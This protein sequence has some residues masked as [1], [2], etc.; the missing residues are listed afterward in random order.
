MT[1]SRAKA[2]GSLEVEVVT[3]LDRAR[4]IQDEWT[5]LAV[6]CDAGPFGHPAFALAW[7]EHLGKGRLHLV[8]VRDGAGTLVGV[9][10]F[11]VRSLGGLDVVRWLG[12]G[13]G[14]V[15]QLLIGRTKADVASTIWEAVDPGRVALQLLEYRH[16]GAGL[17]A[18]RQGRWSVRAE[19]RELCPVIDLRGVA[20]AAELLDR[21][22]RRSLRKHLAK[23]DRRLERDSTKV[24]ITRAETLAQI[25]DALPAVTAVYD[26]AEAARP[27]Q[28]LLRGPYRPFLVAAMEDAARAGHLALLV[29]DID[30][31]PAAFDLHLGI[32]STASVWLGRH[33]PAAAAHSPG[34]L[35]LRAGVDWATAA[36]FDRLDLQ[37]GG[38]EY[39]MRWAFETYDTIGVTAAASP[40]ALARLTTTVAA[41]DTGFRVRSHLRRL[42]HPG[43]SAA[44]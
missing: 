33:H 22:D 8:T 5:E 43:R 24:S 23:T 2:T 41:V 34:H 12:H 32:G 7:W 10:P 6:V 42:T 44:R 28:H 38:D 16:G 21:P 36:G 39:K 26:A 31:E 1:R 37:L 29:A 18:L 27:R 30:G 4:S 3:S 17:L 14:T 13:L 25:R 19:L 11:H 40:R 9:A 35:L 20:G 15:G